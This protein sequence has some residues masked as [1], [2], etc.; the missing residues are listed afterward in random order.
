MGGLLSMG[1]DRSY[2]GFEGHSKMN[3]RSAFMHVGADFLRSVIIVGDSL[4]VKL[5]SAQGR[6]TD[7]IA[8]LIV[9]AT[10]LLGA[11]GAI[12]PWLLQCIRWQKRC[13]AQ[14]SKADV[15]LMAQRM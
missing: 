1:H 11:C 3:M 14:A 2:D 4:V 6:E 13:A 8:S 12:V 7:S 10:I 9:S 15:Q 5:E